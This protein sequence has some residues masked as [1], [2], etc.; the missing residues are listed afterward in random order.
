MHD[1]RLPD[2]LT[3]SANA[4]FE[5]RSRIAEFDFSEFSDS[6]DAALRSSESA[7]RR[8]IRPAK[9]PRAFRPAH[10]PPASRSSGATI[11]PVAHDRSAGPSA[12]RSKNSSRLAATTRGRS[13][14]QRCRTINV[15]IVLPRFAQLT[16]TRVNLNRTAHSRS[17]NRLDR[18][19]PAYTTNAARLCPNSIE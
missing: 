4:S 2:I 16:S 19:P 7:G 10:V 8:F 1:C 11:G 17:S 14:T 9:T 18:S 15:H 5:A 3:W 6:S 13:G 12:G